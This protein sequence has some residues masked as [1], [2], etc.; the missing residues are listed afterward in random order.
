MTWEVK[1]HDDFWK[2]IKHLPEKVTRKLDLV[3]EQLK[4]AGPN[5][6]RLLVD[7]LKGCISI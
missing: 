4:M 2:D 3:L 5:R 7:T 1:F 6:S